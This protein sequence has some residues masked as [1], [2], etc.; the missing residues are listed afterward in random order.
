MMYKLV[1]ALS[2]FGLGAHAEADNVQRR[3]QGFSFGG[4]HENGVSN[5]AME[6]NQSGC[7]PIQQL[8]SFFGAAF[9]FNP[10]ASNA[11]GAR[12]DDEGWCSRAKRVVQ[13]T[14]SWNNRL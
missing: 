5:I 11:G 4:N 7:S 10:D 6:L 13:G 8:N 1:A 12:C 14:K 3:L 2:I 9:G